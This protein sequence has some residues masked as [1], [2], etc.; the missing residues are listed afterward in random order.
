MR[1]FDPVVIQIPTYAQEHIQL[2]YFDIQPIVRNS[3]TV[4]TVK[5]TYKIALQERCSIRVLVF[6]TGHTMYIA[7]AMV[8][9]D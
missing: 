6:A 3:S 5:H 4:G 1:A 9:K 8:V 7:L 2:V